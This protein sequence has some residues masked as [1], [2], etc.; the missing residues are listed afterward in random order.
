MIIIY[1]CLFINLEVK[2]KSDNCEYYDN[3]NVCYFVGQTINS[4]TVKK[5]EMMEKFVEAWINK[6]SQFRPKG[7]RKYSGITFIDCMSN[8]GI[9]TVDDEEIRGSSRRVYDLF[10]HYKKNKF[11]D[12]NYK[13]EVNDLD[14]DAIRCQKCY[15]DENN[16]N[17]DVEFHNRNVKDYLLEVA[18]KIPVVGERHF[19][20]FYD[21]FEA[22]IAWNELVEL[23]TK[24]NQNAY[25]GCDLIISH[26][27]H[28][29]SK[30]GIQQ[31]K[32]QE[33]KMKYENTYQ[34]KFDLLYEKMNELSG[35]EQTEWLRN[36]FVE[37]IGS[38]FNTRIEKIAFAPVFNSNNAAI[39]DIVFYSESLKAK[40]LFKKC[41]YLQEKIVHNHENEQQ[42]FDLFESNTYASIRKDIKEK[43][44]FYSPK[45]FAKEIYNR[46][47]GQ[48]VNDQILTSFLLKHPY[49]PQVGAK[50]EIKKNLTRTYNVKI[51]KDNSGT[52]V[53]DFTE[54][55]P[56][57]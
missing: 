45:Q 25:T 47:K 56:Y 55:S 37:V 15:M 27:I 30:R 11:T 57:Y 13:I 7:K 32:K 20:I 44:I 41:M 34:S 4:G 17:V 12:L 33:V 8:S 22:D 19:L 6:I 26:F 24:I 42:R 40:D 21:P 14:K 51:E 5:L 50:N 35:T 23:V 16:K 48:L 29:D 39:Y 46:F 52:I 53:Y 54:L 28:N 43:E 2:V 1:L 3:N 18:D 49:I 10:N 9:Y 36:K 38:K 31:A